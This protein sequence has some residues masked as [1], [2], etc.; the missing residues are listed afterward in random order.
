MYHIKNDKRSIVSCQMLFEGLKAIMEEKEMDEIKITELVDRS[1]VSRATFYRNFDQII[2]VL[3]LKSDQL[4]EE[5]MVVLREYH[6]KE[7][8]KRSSQFMIPF[9]EF[10]GERTTVVELLLKAKRTDVLQDSMVKMFDS[11]YQSYLEVAKRP[12]ETWDYFVAIRSGIT[13]NILLTW[14][15]NGKNIAPDQL[16]HM[17]FN[18]MSQSMGVD[19]FM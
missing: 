5:L 17:L 12:T 7:P 16:G 9:L 1:G 10:F 4:F 8:V 3:I 14:V 6:Q 18:E 19:A 11:M 2:D 13:V 15:K